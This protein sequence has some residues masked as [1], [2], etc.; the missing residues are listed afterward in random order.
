[1]TSDLTNA[2]LFTDLSAG[3]NDGAAWW[4]ETTDNVRIRVAAWERNAARGTVL[5]FPGRTEYIEKYGPAAQDLADRGYATLAI[6]WRGQGLADRF[7]P[8]RLV[9]HVGHFSEYQTDVAAMVRVARRLDLPKPWFLLGHSMGGC[10]GLR[11]LMEDLPVAAAAFTGPMWG[12]RIAAHMR[13]LAWALG[14]LMPRIGRG[15]ALPPGT[16][17]RPYVQT[18]PFHDNMLTRDLTMFRMMREQLEAQPDLSLGG[19]SFAWVHAALVECRDMAQMASPA[20]PTRTFLGTNE[21]IVDIPRIHDRMDRWT[22]G[23]L[24]LVEGGEHEVLMDT[25]ETRKAV[26]DSMAA[27]FQAHS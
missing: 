10:I 3:P 25:P 6:D 9:G 16:K 12:I 1:M 4:T 17:S 21:R 23:T 13:P 11:S 14:W 27:H 19:P 22:N 26:F 8:D 7:L 5:L 2:P 15:G 20:M 18:D 24:E